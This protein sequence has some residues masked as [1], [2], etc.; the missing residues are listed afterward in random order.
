MKFH[1]PHLTFTAIF[2]SVNH[3]YKIYTQLPVIILISEVVGVTLIEIMYP[4]A[5]MIMLI[6]L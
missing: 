6:T 3:Q 2:M 4:D 1:S 5:V